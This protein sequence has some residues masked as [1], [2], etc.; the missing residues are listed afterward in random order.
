MFPTGCVI[1]ALNTGLISGLV[2]H[3]HYVRGDVKDI[4]T[5]DI[6]L[7]ALFFTYWTAFWASQ[8]TNFKLSKTQE[9]KCVGGIYVW[10][11]VCLLSFLSVLHARSAPH[12]RWKL[13]KMWGNATKGTWSRE[14]TFWVTG[15]DKNR[16][17]ILTIF[18]FW[19]IYL[20]G[21][22]FNLCI[23]HSL[24]LPRKWIIILLKTPFRP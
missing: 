8:C 12:R 9:L 16:G 14:L 24:V 2:S 20:Y 18:S 6:T 22:L 10:R 4:F 13:N 5:A 17:P 23:C 3:C 1:N 15:L 21:P 19:D 7:S 11:S